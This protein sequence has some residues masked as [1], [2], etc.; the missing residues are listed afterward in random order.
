MDELFTDFSYKLFVWQL[1]ILVSIGLYMYCLVDIIKSAFS[2]K[3][4]VF[5]F[6]VV[7]LVPFLGS[8]L[9]LLKG[10]KQKKLNKK[11]LS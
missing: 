5:W 10:T 8:V 2:Q 1:L 4:K 9:Y 6:F 3:T 11:S 7:L